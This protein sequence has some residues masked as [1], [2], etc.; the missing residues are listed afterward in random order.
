MRLPPL[1][2]LTDRTQCA[3]SL[4]DVVST[5]VEAGARAV[6][7]R[8]KDLP[9]AER[10]DLGE[11]L[12]AIL[13]PVDGL[14]ILAGPSGE[15]VHLSAT[16][17]FPASRPALVGRSCHNASEA[18]AATA[19]G[20]DYV[21]LSPVFTTASKPGYGPALDLHGLAEL[22]PVAPPAYALGGVHPPDVAGCLDAGAA[23]VAV[24]G[25]IMRT[26]QL[27]TA[28]LAALQKGGA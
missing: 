19:E 17:A 18:S 21:T 7:L 26:P 4:V 28:Y 16:D 6:L 25:P 3:G 14:L 5:A 10:L 20:C 11:Q 15:A 22:T 13:E 2:V 1:V 24:M 9:A 12:R 8:E 23:G 27:V